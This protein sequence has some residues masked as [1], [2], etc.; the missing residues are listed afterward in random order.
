MKILFAAA[1][2]I[3]LLVPTFAA[4]AKSTDRNQ[5]MTIDAGAQSGTLIGDG[6]TTLSQGVVITQ[7]TLDLRSSDAE[8]YMKDG[9]AVRAVFTGKQAKLKQQLDDGSWMDA[10]ADRIDYDIKSEVLVMTGNYHVKSAR[11]T[12]AGQKMTY[13]TRTGEMNSGG[14]GTRVRTVIPPK[15]KTAAPAAAPAAKTTVPTAGSKK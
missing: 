4:S 1:C 5:D 8:I 11:G 2:A 6:K 15:N 13:N 3:S 14:D 7:G 12:N 9:E 10:S